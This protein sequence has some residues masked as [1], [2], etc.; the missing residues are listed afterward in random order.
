MVATM[1]PDAE[2]L[3]EVLP[4]DRL[5][6]TGMAV[7]EVR[8]RL[9]RIGNVANA[10]TVAGA[11]VQTIAVLY[12]TDLL[13]SRTGWWGLWLGAFVLMARVHAL[14]GILSHE[15]AHRLLFT[16]QRINDWVGKWLVGTVA[17]VGQEA[18]RRGHMG[19]HRD[20]L[21]PNEPDL[22]LYNGYPV[23]SARLRRKLRRDITGESGLK[24][25]SG[26]GR[27]LRNPRS[28]TSTLHII[29]MQALLAAVLGITIAWW[30]WP[31]MWLGSW[32]TIYRLLSRLRA[33]AEHGGL[34]NSTDDRLTTHHVRQSAWA[35]F[36]IV[37]YN[38]GWHVAHHVDAGIPFRNLPEFHR[39]L[40][41]SGWFVPELEYPTY[42][43]LWRRL[44][45]ASAQR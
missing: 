36:W 17:L 18:Y 41:S 43:A 35:R 1:V 11:W 24:L 12:G 14:F 34:V 15:A 38:T 4:T 33:I 20:P 44:G 42:L 37:P 26:I 6:P 21:G 39:E 28:R 10:G 31:V 27:S 2:L 5:G 32:M 13:V 3:P 7:P 9:R 29:A 16:R 30:V 45:S 22:V 25:L 40:V 23:T 8:T 19:H